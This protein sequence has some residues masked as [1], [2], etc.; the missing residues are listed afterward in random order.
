M[1]RNAASVDGEKIKTLRTTKAWTAADLAKKTGLSKRCIED[2]EKGKKVYLSTLRCLA[3][4]FDVPPETLLVGWDT[5]N[6][7]N[8]HIPKATMEFYA[9]SEL[10]VNASDTEINQRATPDTHELSDVA[11]LRRQEQLTILKRA[12]RDGYQLRNGA[13]GICRKLSPQGTI[14]QR[15]WSN[16][17][18]RF[19]LFDFE[20]LSC[21]K[22]FVPASVFVIAHAFKDRCQNFFLEPIWGD[23]DKNNGEP[24]TQ[25][26]LAR[27][28][29]KYEEIDSMFQNM[30][31]AFQGYLGVT[32]SFT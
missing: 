6:R 20:L 24:L 16:F 8:W 18:T 10:S 2:I 30:I 5:E 32:D 17:E 31:I 14:D 1:A 9:S 21:L 27:L 15:L 23:H 26:Q 19:G 11:R 4:A 25:Q 12:V 29:T 3:E 13:R 28:N 7:R 22:L